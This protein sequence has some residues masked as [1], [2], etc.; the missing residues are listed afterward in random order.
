M[1]PQPESYWGNVNPIGPRSMYDESKPFAE[2]VAMAYQRS[3]GMDTRIFRFFNSY[4]PG[5][6]IDDG[7]VVAAFCRQAL[8]GKPIH[9]YD[10]GKQTRS[11]CC[12]GDTV[13]AI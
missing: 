3:Y 12:I 2:A 8:E 13:E 7:R 6:K 9:I 1:Y 4:G 11:L 10:D 5:L